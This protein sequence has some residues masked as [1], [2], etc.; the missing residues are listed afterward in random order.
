MCSAYHCP[1]LN[2]VF[3]QHTQIVAVKTKKSKSGGVC[4]V[5]SRQAVEE[6]NLKA[7]NY[8]DLLSDEEFSR[9]EGVITLQ[10]P[11]RGPRDKSGF[12]HVKR[13]LVEAPTHAR[14]GLGNVSE[15]VR[16]VLQKI[17]KGDGPAALAAGGGGAL[18]EAERLLAVERANEAR[19][20]EART[21]RD[22]RP[23]A[24]A[25]AEPSSD[26]EHKSNWLVIDRRPGTHTWNTDV[27]AV[28]ARR[29]GENDMSTSHGVR[30]G[31][32][33][34]FHDKRAASKSA[35]GDSRAFTSSLYIPPIAVKRKREDDSDK[36]T[37]PA[38]S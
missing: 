38:H 16:R 5:Y 19:A 27:G 23:V 25:Q 11:T 30:G 13:A 33:S 2:K 36:G 10:D 14:A 12:D 4:N 28:A 29:S 15:D 18:A 8:R 26:T 22:V 21:E 24:N 7:K 32:E 17:E 37:A 9:K 31:K 6:L 1:V 20:K 3:N 35:A 34:I